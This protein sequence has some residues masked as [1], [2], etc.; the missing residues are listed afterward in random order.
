MRV[1]E[2]LVTRLSKG[3]VTGVLTDMLTSAANGLV[4]AA[5]EA[6]DSASSMVLA[7]EDPEVGIITRD[8]VSPGGV[9]FFIFLLLGVGTFL[10]WR[11]MNKQL[12]RID[13]DEGASPRDDVVDMTDSAEAGATG[14][15][16]DPGGAISEGSSGETDA[17]S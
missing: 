1:P 16:L 4:G 13:F 14:A 3:S 11:S 2:R 15:L 10:I 8:N 12:K 5:R 6:V 9:G 17:E 7:A